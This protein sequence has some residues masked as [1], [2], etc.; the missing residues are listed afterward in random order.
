MAIS[1]FF[2]LWVTLIT[3]VCS[4]S[5]PSG[6]RGIEKRSDCSNGPWAG[7][8]RIGSD[9]QSPQPQSDGRQVL[10]AFCHY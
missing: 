10:T 8:Y 5:I 9:G 3:L 7:P 4:A 2:L 1:S 6:S